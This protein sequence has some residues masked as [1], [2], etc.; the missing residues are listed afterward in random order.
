MYTNGLGSQQ[1]ALEFCEKRRSVYPPIYNGNRLKEYSS[2]ID[3]T[4]FKAAQ[5]D[6]DFRM[7]RLVILVKRLNEELGIEDLTIEN[8]RESAED[9]EMNIGNDGFDAEAD[10]EVN[11]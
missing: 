1:S 5:K 7:D 11:R 2:D 3:M 6:D 9:D 10:C 4:S 8:E